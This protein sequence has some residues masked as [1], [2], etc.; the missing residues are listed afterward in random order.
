[1]EKIIC[2]PSTIWGLFF[3]LISYAGGILIGR[4]NKAH[5]KYTEHDMALAYEFAER[6]TRRAKDDPTYMPMSFDAFKNIQNK[7]G[8]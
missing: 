8:K 7:E 4:W 1:M 3:I 5:K 2:D 6:E